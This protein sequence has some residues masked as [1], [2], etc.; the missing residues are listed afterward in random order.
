[1][2]QCIL[3][4]F[5]NSLMSSDYFT[6]KEFDN[7]KYII[8]KG[9]VVRKVLNQYPNLKA[10]ASTSIL[11][12]EFPYRHGIFFDNFDI[13]VRRY[14]EKEYEDIRVP[15]ILDLFKENG[16]NVSV[17]SWPIMGNSNFKYN[18]M[19][20]KS[21]KFHDIVRGILKGSSF[22]M[23]KNILKYSN[24]LKVNMQPENDNFSSI[25]AMELLEK[26]KSNVIFLNFNH[27][28]YA[29]RRYYENSENTIDALKSID[30][31]VGDF[32]S[33]CD[34]KNILKD[35]TMF[36]VSN[37]GVYDCKNSININY[38]FLK[39]DL[40][41]INNRGKIKNYIAYA[42]CDGGSAFI[43]L[44]NPNNA[45][46]YGRVKVFLDDF[47]KKNSNFIKD[48]YETHGYESFDLNNFSFRL[49]GKPNCIFDGGV[50]KVSFV[51]EIN[52]DTCFLN[53]KV[54]RSFSGYS[55]EYENSSGM[56]IS[57]GNR[58]SEGI[59]IEK[60]SIV[61]IA[62]TIASFMDLRFESSGKVIKGIRK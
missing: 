20:I 50:N 53:S 28:D 22:Y 6:L 32:L 59:E 37:G 15:T 33:W 2:K 12:G 31:R 13:C 38:A 1:M 21:T 17:I 10:P 58:V 46:D 45:N 29:R 7:F 49:E 25:L 55:N 61:D 24:I 5:V 11:T 3:V 18:F 4:M 23:L 34:N 14:R 8:S 48:V 62:P 26:R 54:N 44:K 30:R 39:N 16:N 52:L 36:V 19:N 47:V 57:Y 40:L 56:F 35:L 41:S 27:L 9:A 51:E 43:Y 42:H 60:C